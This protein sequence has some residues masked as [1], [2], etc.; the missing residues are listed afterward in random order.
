MVNLI[1][2]TIQINTLERLLVNWAS[3]TD[4][5]FYLIRAQSKP[6]SYPQKSFFEEIQVIWFR[7]INK[8]PKLLLIKENHSGH[9][10][11]KIDRINFR[12]VFDCG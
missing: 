8:Y 3:M 12:E 7:R 9:I 2:S 5:F 11:S 10:S 4:A 1:N 6:N